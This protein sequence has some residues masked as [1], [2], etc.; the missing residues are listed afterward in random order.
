M[1]VQRAF[2]NDEEVKAQEG[3]YVLYIAI[4]CCIPLKKELIGMVLK[5]TAQ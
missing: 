2:V 4:T 5:S 3:S 1:Q